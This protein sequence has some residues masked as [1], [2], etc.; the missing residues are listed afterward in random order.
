MK[1]QNNLNEE[2][3]KQFRDFWFWAY[4]ILII[5]IVVIFNIFKSSKTLTVASLFCL[6]IIQIIY[7]SF[8]IK[9]EYNK[10]KWEKF[11]SLGYGILLFIFAIINLALNVGE[12]TTAVSL[13]LFTSG[14]IMLGFV[15]VLFNLLWKSETLIGTLIFY[16]LFTFAIVYLFAFGYSILAGFEGQTVINFSGN[17]LDTRFEFVTYSY[18]N[19]YNSV[20]GNISQGYS[21]IL[22]IIQIVFSYI[23]HIIVLGC[24]I[25]RKLICKLKKN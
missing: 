15:I 5:V 4:L 17:A 13:L 2:L 7:G 10:T 6:A 21:T 24:I 18:G 19:F 3:I 11:N 1:N 8:Q 23:F 9:R 22:S 12:L 20:N 14:L 25:Q 16:L